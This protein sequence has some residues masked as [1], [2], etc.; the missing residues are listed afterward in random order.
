MILIKVIS[1]N[2]KNDYKKFCG[3]RLIFCEFFCFYALKDDIF[4]LFGNR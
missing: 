3:S 4:H 2:M 1:Q